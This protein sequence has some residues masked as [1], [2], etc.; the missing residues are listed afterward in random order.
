MGINTHLRGPA[1]AHLIST[2]HP[3][4]YRLP[5]PGESEELLVISCVCKMVNTTYL[6]SH[7]VCELLEFGGDGFTLASLLLLDQT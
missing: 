1:P 6:C 2:S 4:I 5:C 7:L 3:D